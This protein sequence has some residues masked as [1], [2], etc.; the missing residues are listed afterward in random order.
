MDNGPNLTGDL[1]KRL[2]TLGAKVT[3][4][5][6]FTKEGLELLADAVELADE[7]ALAAIESHGRLTDWD[8]P[9]ERGYDI[10]GE[11]V[12]ADAAYLE[13]RGLLRRTPMAPTL[14]I[15]QPDV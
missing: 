5:H 7:A 12:E 10:A 2:R 8:K 3:P 14:V 4:A 13:R 9:G 11:P 6:D 15:L 1:P